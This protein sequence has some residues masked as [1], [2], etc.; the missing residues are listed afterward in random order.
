M[1]ATEWN[2]LDGYEALVAELRSTAPV[3]PERLRQRV[4]ELA[5][6]A[7]SRRR[8]LVLVLA[9]AAVAAAVGAALI[10]GVVSS[11]KSPAAAGEAVLAP[12]KEF[13]RLSSPKAARKQLSGTSHGAPL[14]GPAYSASGANS[15][16][17]RSFEQSTDSAAERAVA[18]PSKR[19]VH[20]DASL[21][22]QVRSHGALTTATN[23]ATQIVSSLGGYAQSVQYQSSRQGYGDAFLALRVPLGKAEKAIGQLAGLGKLVSQEVSTRD[24]QQQ[25]TKEND[26]I[27]SLHRAIAIYEQ[28]LRSG[29]LSASERVQIEI[30]LANARHT[31]A[32]VRRARTGTLASGA[33]ADI[34]L[35]LTTNK[36]AGIVPTHH[37]SGRFTRLL[38]SAA[39]FL[40]L[41]GIIVL[42]ALVVISPLL[43]LGA[44]AWWVLRER[45]RREE[46]LLASA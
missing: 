40:G 22:V 1:S 8:R 20:A 33:T 36:S 41:E 9:P 24:L 6:V 44:L 14:H 31:A 13:P 10:H 29:S 18:I 3:A 23:K 28:A 11:G 46:R 43:V 45:R 34:S 16:T 32:Q 26:R 7:R 27:G 4:L 19:L 30:K 42:Y 15:T 35:T 37:K 38:G 17:G 5:P 39:G 2:D 25:L 12:R 21:Q